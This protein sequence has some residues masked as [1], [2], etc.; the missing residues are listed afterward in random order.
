M[1][2]SNINANYKMREI[3]SHPIKYRFV[4]LKYLHGVHKRMP[5]TY[6]LSQFH[7]LQTVIDDSGVEAF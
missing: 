6:V 2:S 3:I 5:L 7:D 4:L 1:A